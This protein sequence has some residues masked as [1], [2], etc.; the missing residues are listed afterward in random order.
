MR[1]ILFKAVKIDGSGW[2]EGDLVHGLSEKIYIYPLENAFGI[3]V[4]PETVCQY[5][6]L[7]DKDGKRIFEGDKIT[8][9]SIR[10]SRRIIMPKE[11][12]IGFEMHN[13]YEE[14]KHFRYTIS[15]IDAE[16][17]EHSTLLCNIHDHLVTTKPT[18]NE[19]H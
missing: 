4:I 8:P 14:S 9:D 12:F 16:D 3:E 17:I 15:D 11:D 6:G 1:E 5:T 2:V 13:Y 10:F 18:T 7:K 19:N